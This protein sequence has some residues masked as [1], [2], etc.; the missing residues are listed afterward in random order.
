MKPRHLSWIQT[1]PEKTQVVEWWGR[2]G[3][4]G[5]GESHLLL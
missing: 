2:T 1:Q 3:A 4:W 5:G